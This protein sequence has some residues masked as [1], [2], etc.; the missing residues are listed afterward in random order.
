MFD[1]IYFHLKSAKKWDEK[2]FWYQFLLLVPQMGFTFLSI[3]LPSY[4][5][6][7]LQENVSLAVLLTRISII[8]I[9]MAFCNIVSSGMEQYLYR[10]SMSLTLFYEQLLFRKMTRV[11]YHTLEEEKTHT[12]LGNIWNGFRNEYM[13]R[14]SVTSFSAL[15]ESMLASCI[16]G[17]L[18]FRIHYLLFAIITMSVILN[19]AFLR[20]SREKQS[21]IY[22]EIGEPMKLVSYIKRHSM[23]RSDGKDIR[24]YQMQEWF[25]RKYDAAVLR[26]SELYGKIHKYYFIRQL[27]ELGIQGLTEFLSY[28]YMAV[29]LANGEIQISE[30]VFAVGVI[31]VFSGH[32]STL[33][34]RLQEQN[35]I[36]SF[37]TNTRQMLSYPEEDENKDILPLDGDNGITIELRNVSFQ[38]ENAKEA[39]LKNINLTMH[40]GEKLALIGLN[41]AGKTTLVKLICGF[42]EPTEGEIY[43]NGNPKSS[44]SQKDY[45]SKVSVLFQD[46]F[47]FPL[48]L[49][50]NL[51]GCVSEAVS[52]ESLRE[53][54]E[55]SGF[56]EAY[57]RCGQKGKTM[58]VRE[59]NENATD[60]SGGEKQK[61]LFARALYKQAQI[62]ILDE[63][64]AALDPIAENELYQN[65]GRAAKDHTVLF[66]SHRLSST[67]FC[68]RIILL[69]GAHIVEE[70]THEELMR[71]CGRYSELFE[72]QS[73][74]YKESYQKGENCNE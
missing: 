27:G 43:I 16:Y 66:I 73:K 1:N 34:K 54:L 64:T 71:K 63:P 25:I 42:Y 33:I 13:I 50:E 46:S 51:T 45:I 7:I 44:Y 14:N 53:A 9:G 47:V 74:Y 61:L 4:I 26:L 62:L 52:E 19:F 8:V 29:K 23:E 30:F 22:Q 12:L 2:L 41:G 36:Q 40:A 24:V 6:T 65:F 21:E 68:D 31:R 58:L 48:S 72:I 57:H 18:V 38:Y 3:L 69:E 17:Y 49:D 20:K 55:Y 11:S 60:F 37:L 59:V 56:S 28:G 70:G 67:R 35:G 10:N 5:V 15:L 39:V 32:F